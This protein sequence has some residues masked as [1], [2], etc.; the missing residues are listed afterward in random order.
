MTTGSDGDGLGAAIIQ[1]S[2]HAEQ[3]GAL[4]A[5]ETSHHQHTTAQLQE[6]T[7]STTAASTRINDIAGALARQAA[8]T[9]AL[10]GIDEHVA[11]LARQLADLT[12]DVE[13]DEPAQRPYRPLPQPRWWNL[14]WPTLGRA[15][16]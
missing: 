1:I 9:E 5:R 2:A 16:K 10:D 3:V 15:E 13:D 11:A 14:S 7:A 4:H 6:L 12:A 8:V